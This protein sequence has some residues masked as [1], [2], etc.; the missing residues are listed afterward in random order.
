[1]NPSPKENRRRSV[2]MRRLRHHNEE[3][4]I[5]YEDEQTNDHEMATSNYELRYVV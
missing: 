4:T 1:V 5:K 2:D 3:T